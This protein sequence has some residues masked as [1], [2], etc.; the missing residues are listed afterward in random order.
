MAKFLK[1]LNKQNH[2][3]DFEF[4][5][6]TFAINLSSKTICR[7]KIVIEKSI[8]ADFFSYSLYF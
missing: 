1:R 8:L 7:I 4:K 5:F 2:K 3:Y 6:L